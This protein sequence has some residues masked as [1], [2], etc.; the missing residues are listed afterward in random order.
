MT[1]KG[2]LTQI[3]EL[4]TQDIETLSRSQFD[5]EKFIYRSLLLNV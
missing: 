5:I 1:K 3:E 2:I 4:T